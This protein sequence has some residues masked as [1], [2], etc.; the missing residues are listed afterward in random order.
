MHVLHIFSPFWFPVSQSLA[1]QQFSFQI[2]SG[3]FPYSRC[4]WS[5][6]RDGCLAVLLRECNTMFWSRQDCRMRSLTL[7]ARRKIAKVCQWYTLLVPNSIVLRV[8]RGTVM[9]K[10]WYH[11]PWFSTRWGEIVGQ[12]WRHRAK[13]LLD[14]PHNRST[15]DRSIVDETI[16]SKL[17]YFIC[18]S[19]VLDIHAML[20]SG[21][22]RKILTIWIV[23]FTSKEEYS[24][25]FVS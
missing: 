1:P 2:F 24:T 15:G 8:L 13:G 23:K 3:G 16:Y 20:I 25:K 11:L 14:L 19:T 18:F 7:G 4:L 12:Y 21:T 6:M 22:K 10:P 17:Q 9:F 5:H